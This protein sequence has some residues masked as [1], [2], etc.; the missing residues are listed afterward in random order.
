MKHTHVI[1][2]KTN[3]FHYSAY[4]KVTRVSS[5][6]KT[7]EKLIRIERLFLELYVKKVSTVQCIFISDTLL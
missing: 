1:N 6:Q 2:I 3:A 7:R 5:V 4:K